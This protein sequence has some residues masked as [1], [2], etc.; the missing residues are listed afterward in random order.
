[1][2]IIETKISLHDVLGVINELKPTL[3][4]QNRHVLLMTGLMIASLA[5]KPSIEADEARGAIRGMSE[6]LSLY[7]AETSATK[8]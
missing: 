1:M 5:M 7:L 2:D 3:D 8:Q 4:K 6:W